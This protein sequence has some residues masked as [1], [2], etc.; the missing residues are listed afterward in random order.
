MKSYRVGSLG[1]KLALFTCSALFANTLLLANSVSDHENIRNNC[2]V[3]I[4]AIDQVALERERVKTEARVIARLLRGFDDC[5]VDGRLKQAGE[6]NSEDGEPKSEDSHNALR[7]PQDRPSSDTST[8]DAP[9]LVSN[10]VE[11]SGASARFSSR[12]MVTKSQSHS[13]EP[14]VAESDA[15][16]EGER[17]DA[18]T[19]DFASEIMAR[20]KQRETLNPE[21]PATFRTYREG[22]QQ[23]A[24]LVEEVPLDDYANVIYEAYLAET[25]SVLKDALANELTKYL[26]LD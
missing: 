22:K 20:S 7:S 1:S 5:V 24:I 19:T 12:N 2:K 18:K 25:D 14:N 3:F 16:R 11:N 26:K 21:K 9:K 6:I 4:H 23:L 10:R 15:E 13:T 17:R 8:I